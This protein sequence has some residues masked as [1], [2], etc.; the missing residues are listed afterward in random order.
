MMRV[1][2]FNLVKII[3]LKN[4]N[5]ALILRKWLFCVAKPTLLERKTA[6]FAQQLIN[7]NEEISKLV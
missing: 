2:R 3:L 1:F 5:C 4:N 6:A 7:E